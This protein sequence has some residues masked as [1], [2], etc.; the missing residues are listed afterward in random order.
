[1][2]GP[3]GGYEMSPGV[4]VLWTPGHTEEDAS[5]LVET[6]EGIYVLTHLWSLP[7]MTTEEDPLA[8]NQAK[9]EK[10]RHKIVPLADWIIPGYGQ[11]FKNPR[12]G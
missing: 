6:A 11:L 7:D 12:K 2:V 8:C 10:S 3:W 5:L 4:K 9:L 1:M